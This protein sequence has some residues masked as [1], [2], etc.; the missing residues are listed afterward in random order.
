MTRSIHETTHEFL[1][2]LGR[3]DIH[4]DSIK[5]ATKRVKLIINEFE[6]RVENRI[7]GGKA[8]RKGPRK[9]VRTTFKHLI[10]AAKDA[11]P[12]D[13]SSISQRARDLLRAIRTFPNFEAME[14]KARGFAGFRWKEIRR[15]NQR[16][17]RER[18]PSITIGTSLLLRQLA[19]V[20]DLRSVSL[21]L[22]L[23]AHDPDWGYLEALRD[24]SRDFWVIQRNDDPIALL[25]IDRDEMKVS[26]A[27]GF[28]HEPI[29]LSRFVMLEVLRELRSS[30][31]DCKSFSS[32]G[33]Y[34]LFLS[35]SVPQP[36]S[37][38][39]D[40]SVYRVWGTDGVVV[41]SRDEHHWSQFRW[42][43][44]ECGWDAGSD[45]DIG[46]G[47]LV[48]LLS[49]CPGL[50]EAIRGH[51][52]PQASEPS[53]INPRCPRRRRPRTLGPRHRGRRRRRG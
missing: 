21:T 50:A 28:N 37:I 4:P 25:A 45:N 17:I 3:A 13:R 32:V 27:D 33:A 42:N 10:R 1:A 34:S 39:F 5:Q 22:R 48:D 51:R 52:L 30:A 11:R 8:V 2:G 43:D 31:D 6:Q 19:T 46:L 35:D 41:I 23:C 44:E 12:G 16:K 24:R 9:R 29:G 7:E 36:T 40:D 26:E 18:A 15:Q 49:C 53:P 14:E 20:D 47:R 38:E